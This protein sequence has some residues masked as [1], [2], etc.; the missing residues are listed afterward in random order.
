MRICMVT[1]SLYESDGRVMRYAEALAA[2]GDEVEVIALRKSGLPKEETIAGVRVFRIQS[3]S[4]T[5]KKKLAFLRQVSLFFLKAGWFLSRRHLQK[6]YDLFHIHSIPDYLVF[7]AL[8]P[9]LMG[10]KIILDIH[11]ILPELYA[12]KFGVSQKSIGFRTMMLLE[13]ISTAFSDHVIIANH[14]WEERLVA[15]A[16]KKGNGTVL[17]NYPDRTLFHPMRR[18]G[19][20]DKFVMLYPGTLNQ[21]QGLDV[22][23]RA[24]AIVRKTAADIEFHIYGEGRTQA[25]LQQL[26]STLGVEDAV[27]FCKFRPQKEIARVM[28]NADLA[29]VPKRK[30]SF[31]NEAFSTKVFEFMSLGVPVVVSDTKIDQYYFNDSV[32][33]FFRDGDENDLARCILLLKNDAAL[34]ARLVSNALEFVKAYDWEANKG[35]YLEIVDSLV[36]GKRQPKAAAS[37]TKLEDAA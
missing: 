21:H 23:I 27:R 12:S 35:A 1:H 14:L 15:R 20:R 3:R 34:R 22:A 10:A 18:E 9:K 30:D 29:V 16:V 8:L 25:E 2:R 31:G 33:K 11:D 24:L 4:F 13:R 28:A 26:A 37:K 17:L 36:I 5:E 32:V 7:T 6:P 19:P